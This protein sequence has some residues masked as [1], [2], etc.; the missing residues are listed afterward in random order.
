MGIT[1]RVRLHDLRGSYIDLVLASGISPKFAQNQVGHAKNSI[2]MDCY[3]RNNLDMVKTATDTMGTFFNL[4]GKMVEKNKIEE[5][6]N[7]ISFCDRLTK[8]NSGR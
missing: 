3:E 4:G 1:K 8:R 2:T 7:L 5:K 6:T